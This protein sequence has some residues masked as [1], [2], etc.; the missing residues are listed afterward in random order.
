M[1]HLC[2]SW[3]P[4]YYYALLVVHSMWELWQVG[5][6][7]TKPWKVAGDNNL[8]DVFVDTSLFLLGGVHREES[9]RSMMLQ[10]K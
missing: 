10:K 2:C 1:L 4:Y 9:G 8:M 5:I 6:G 3:V 7:M